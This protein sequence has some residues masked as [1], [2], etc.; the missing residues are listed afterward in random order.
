MSLKDGSR[1]YRA[2][3]SETESWKFLR[4]RGDGLSCA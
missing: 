1:R 4:A 3:G 2:D